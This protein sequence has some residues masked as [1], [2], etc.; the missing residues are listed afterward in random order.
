MNKFVPILVLLS[1]TIL[2]SRAKDL[3]PLIPLWYAK[4]WGE[5]QLANPW[6]LTILPATSLIVYVINVLAGV[7]LTTE[8]L[9]FTQLLYFTSLVVSFL[10]FITLLKIVF[11]IT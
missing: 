11:L 5:E 6:W 4:P 2:L 3:P 1:I 10:S 9:V 7:Y 8:H